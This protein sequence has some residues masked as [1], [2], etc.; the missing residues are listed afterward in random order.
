MAI[1]KRF[2][3]LAAISLLLAPPLASQ[4]E[5]TW[6]N[7]K[8]ASLMMQ[9]KNFVP[10]DSF[11]PPPSQTQLVGKPFLVTWPLKPGDVRQMGITTSGYW[12]YNTANSLLSVVISSSLSEPGRF[13][14]QAA[15][16]EGK[17]YAAQNGF[18]ATANV[19]KF[20]SLGLGIEAVNKLPAPLE[21]QLNIA[22]D[23]ARQL[24]NSLRIELRGEFVAGREGSTASCATDRLEPTVQRPIEM[25]MTNCRASAKINRVTIVRS[26]T[27]QLLKEWAVY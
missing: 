16:S 19:K 22:G 7:A 15:T 24:A 1:L 26:D 11:D 18:G 27:G 4:S 17:A 21:F 14:F 13:T 6:S 3:T 8:L 23:A 20:E 2:A 12:S 25:L 5:G 9:V 10:K